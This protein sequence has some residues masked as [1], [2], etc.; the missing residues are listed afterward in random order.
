MPV[1]LRLRSLSLHL[2]REFSASHPPPHTHTHYLGVC[3][4]FIQEVR[5]PPP[6][7]PQGLICSLQVKLVGK[8]SW[9]FSREAQHP[10]GQDLTQGEPCY[11]GIRPR[12]AVSSHQT[13]LEARGTTMASL[14]LKEWVWRYPPH[15]HTSTVS[16]LSQM[17]ETWS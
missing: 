11:G 3:Y 15:T 17:Q 9:L 1:F 6:P 5:T 4:P 8:E 13:T 2:A 14:A 10:D 7:P 12:G 16:L